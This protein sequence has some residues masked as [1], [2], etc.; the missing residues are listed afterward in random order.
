MGFY[1]A[2]QLAL[3]NLTLFLPSTKFRSDNSFV[4]IL[5]PKIFELAAYLGH[6]GILPSVGAVSSAA[7]SPVRKSLQTRRRALTIF[8]GNLHYQLKGTGSPE[9]AVHVRAILDA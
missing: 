3:L 9:M 7:M 4:R 2:P 6:Q 5:L 1:T 8:S